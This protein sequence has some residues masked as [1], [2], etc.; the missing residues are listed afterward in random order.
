M[1]ET[2][3]EDIKLCVLYGKRHSSKSLCFALC[4]DITEMVLCVCGI[5]RYGNE[6]ML[7]NTSIEYR[8]IFAYFRIPI[9]FRILL[10]PFW[11]VYI[12]IQMGMWIATSANIGRNHHQ[13]ITVVIFTRRTPTF[14]L[15]VCAFNTM[16]SILH[17]HT[18]THT[19]TKHKTHTQIYVR[20]Y[21]RITTCRKIL[22][23]IREE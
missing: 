23:M 1:S 11:N 5:C 8:N 6:K 10:I 15:D 22:N 9:V 12:R 7:R 13:N 3:N 21:V 18:H 14:V 2:T 17:T 19:H 20:T 4:H 16:C